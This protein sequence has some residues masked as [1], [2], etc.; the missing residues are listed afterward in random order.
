MISFSPLTKL[1]KIEL[2]FLDEAELEENVESD[3]LGI[4]LK[5]DL[6]YFADLTL[7]IL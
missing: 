5:K 6:R 7:D 1:A 2:L 4:V 3:D